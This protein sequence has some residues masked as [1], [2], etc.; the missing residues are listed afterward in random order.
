MTSL[1]KCVILAGSQ[2]RMVSFSH[3]R[4]LPCSN[5]LIVILSHSPIV[6]LTHSLIIA[7]PHRAKSCVQFMVLGAR[8]AVVALCMII[9]RHHFQHRGHLFQH[10]GH[11]Y[12]NSGPSAD[13]PYGD[14]PLWREFQMCGHIPS[15]PQSA[16]TQPS[17]C[18]C[19]SRIFF[20]RFQ[21]CRAQIKLE[22]SNT[23]H[24][25]LHCSNVS[26]SHCSIVSL[27]HSPIVSLSHCLLVT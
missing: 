8:D 7:L 5:C 1:R 18:A 17:P 23:K 15:S 4:I 13:G 11:L 9:R 21:K 24:R 19:A 26:L 22:V 3:C 12:H 10:R 27:W 20:W 14:G 6:S 2:C 16:K 25:R